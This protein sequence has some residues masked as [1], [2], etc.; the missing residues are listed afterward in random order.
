MDFDEIWYLS[1]FFFKY[2]EKVQVWLNPANNYG[3]FTWKLADIYDN[4]SQ[5][6]FLEWQMYRI[7][8]VEKIAT[9]ILSSKSCSAAQSCRREKMYLSRIIRKAI[10]ITNV[11]K[12]HY[13]ETKT[14]NTTVTYVPDST[15][16]V[17]S[18]VQ[19]KTGWRLGVVA[20]VRR[21]PGFGLG[22]LVSFFLPAVLGSQS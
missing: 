16:S 19:W 3:C 8:F 12:H 5:I 20:Q 6:S 7:R 17:S 10:P 21:G 2:A 22:L 11:Y 4:I 9:Y 1:N 18:S 13:L 14:Q 15:S